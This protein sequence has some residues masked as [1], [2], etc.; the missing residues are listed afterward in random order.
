MVAKKQNNIVEKIEKHQLKDSKKTKK[1]LT[2]LKKTIKK[3]KTKKNKI[4]FEVT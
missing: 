3:R 4:R 1:F 2:N